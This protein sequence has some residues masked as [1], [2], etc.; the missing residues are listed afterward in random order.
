M[1]THRSSRNVFSQPVL[2]PKNVDGHVQ[3]MN[4]WSTRETKQ[5][6]AEKMG[7]KYSDIDFSNK[8][9]S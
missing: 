1:H 4:F 8:R 5:G 7:L 3:Y 6:E 2:P 9:L